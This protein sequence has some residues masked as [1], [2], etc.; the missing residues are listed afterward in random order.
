MK[1]SPG[2]VT[3]LLAEW[4]QG[5]KDAL[6]RLV[7]LVYSELRRLAGSYLK[8]ERVGH[9]LR[10]LPRFT[11]PTFDWLDRIALAGRIAPIFWA[12]PRG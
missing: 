8:A 6:D 7:P 5:R 12:W 10:Q 9:T 4:S 3:R 1:Q 11:K 2:E